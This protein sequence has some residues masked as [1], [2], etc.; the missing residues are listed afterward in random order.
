VNEPWTKLLST[1]RRKKKAADEVEERFFR[2]AF[3][4]DYDRIL[5]CSAVRR[6]ADKTQLFPLEKHDGVRTRLTH[7]LEVSNVA[8]SLG[9][10]LVLDGAFGSGDDSYLIRAIP[11]LLAAIGLAHDLG[12]PPFGHQGEAAIS[13]WVRGAL[14]TRP[15]T[16]ELR[17]GLSNVR[18]GAQFLDPAEP[19]GGLWA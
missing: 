11:A 10:A 5:F 19:L 15:K 7:S 18:L 14:G 1:F 16:S 12:N 2:L 6:L 8:R 3:E 17:W 4:R 13:R 9:R